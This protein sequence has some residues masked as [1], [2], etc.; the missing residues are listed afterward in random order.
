MTDKELIEFIKFK[1]NTW[2]LHSRNTNDVIR[3]DLERPIFEKIKEYE[4]SKKNEL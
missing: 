2:Q 1:F 3:Y 4:D